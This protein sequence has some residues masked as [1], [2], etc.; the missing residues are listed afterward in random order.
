MREMIKAAGNHFEYVI[1]DSPPMSLI[2]DAEILAG[3]SDMSLLVVRYDR[4][5][6][7]AIN[8]AI[9]TLTGC[10]A[11]FYGCILNGVS[12]HSR[13]SGYGYGY[14]GYQ[15]SHYSAAAENTED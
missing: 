3:L 13:R 14:Y 5:R 7:G 4:A 10:K 6:I 11:D 8:N 15:A 12:S 1:I 2:A 9:D